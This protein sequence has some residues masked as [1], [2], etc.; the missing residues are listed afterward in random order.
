MFLGIDIG[1]HGIKGGLLHGDHLLKTHRIS[2]SGQEDVKLFLE[3]V[4]SFV[5]LFESHTL[6]AIGIGIPG[7]VDPEAGIVYNIQNIPLLKEVHLKETLELAFGIP[8]FVNNDANC[9]VLGEN[10]FG[11]GKQY[12]NFLGVTLGTGL[13]TGIIIKN[14]LYSGVLCGAGEIGILPYK[15]GIIE[16]YTGS[17]FFKKHGTTGAIAYQQALEN[18]QKALAIFREYGEHLGNVISIILHVYAPEAIVLGGAIAKAFPFFESS[19]NQKLA[20][21]PFQKQLSNFNVHTSEQANMGIL[22]AAALCI[23]FTES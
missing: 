8:V 6:R 1:G 22:G 10:Y 9:F 3:K 23:E 15:N 5:S 19:M 20:T 17:F 14:H 13:G 4:K 11:V 18:D 7:I 12:A 21:F 2:I 16:Q